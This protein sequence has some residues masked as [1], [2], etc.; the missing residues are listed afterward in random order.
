MIADLLA[1]TDT[2]SDEF[3][4]RCHGLFLTCLTRS[5]RASNLEEQ[6]SKRVLGMRRHSFADLAQLGEALL[7]V[8]SD[9][10][11]GFKH[12]F[13]KHED[14]LGFSE[15]TATR[16]KAA[17]QAVRTHGLETA[18][19]LAQQRCTDRPP[20]LLADTLRLAKP[21]EEMTIE[22][23]ARWKQRLLPWV[24]TYQLLI[25]YENDGAR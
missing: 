5:T 24:E 19:T 25:S 21:V 22:E 8:P 9:Q 14:R 15:S 12:W 17:A 4:D 1:I 11:G 3:V 7:R 16:A 10:P 13:D 6:T 18:F 23:R 20:P 2:D